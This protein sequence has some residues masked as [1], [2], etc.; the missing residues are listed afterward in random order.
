MK[1]ILIAVILS[2]LYLPTP[3][4]ATE[5]KCSDAVGDFQGRKVRS[6]KVVPPRWAKP[7]SLDEG[8]VKDNSGG[9]LA[10]GKEF[11]T[12]KLGNTM[13]AARHAYKNSRIQ[14]GFKLFE[15]DGAIEATV[16]P[17][18]CVEP[19]DTS[20]CDRCVDVTVRPYTVAIDFYRVG[21]NFLPIPRSNLPTAIAEVPKPLR[22]LD[23]SFGLSRDNEQGVSVQAGIDTD[24]LHPF[25]KREEP[26]SSDSPETLH[27][28]LRASG[29]K[30]LSKRFYRGRIALEMSQSKGSKF[31]E[32]IAVGGSFNSTH[33]P[34]G[35]GERFANELRLGT[36]LTL[37]PRA[38][39]LDTV[40]LRANYRHSN[41]RFFTPEPADAEFV[42]ENSAELRTVIDGRAAGGFSR[43]GV[44]FDANRGSGSYG[45]AAAQVG[46][47]KEIP[48]DLNRTIGLEFLAGAGKIWG[49]APEYARF[50]SGSGSANFLYAQIEDSQLIDFP[51]GPVLRSTGG[52]RGTL[53]DRKGGTSF[54]HTNLNVSFPVPGW[55]RPLI[56]NE[57]IDEVE[58]DE[59]EDGEIDLPVRPAGINN[60]PSSCRGHQG[61][62]ATLKSLVKS[63]VRSSFNIIRRYYLRLGMSPDEA[64][65]AAE[66]D[67][68]EICP[69]VFYIADYANLFE[70]KPMIMFDASHLGGG[71][72]TGHTS[73][74]AGAGAQFILV[75][76]RLE[77][78]YMKALKRSIHEQNGSIVF[79]LVFQN[80]F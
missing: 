57:S 20:E 25:S 17:S 26:A 78:G 45:R 43:I 39:V 12:E 13:T 63:S 3:G 48:L 44:W 50:H 80:L 2:A 27:L 40:L 29:E 55:S 69:G 18:P 49:R 59:D 34:F 70:V 14:N 72:A 38:A 1:A 62:P 11:T 16:I 56:P 10:A 31:L 4:Q 21:K 67:L 46:Y 52:N 36:R 6:L 30:S 75:T 77:L 22:M 54:W 74:A 7:M 35:V 73:Y 15:R 24:L 28:N 66:D 41:I 37:R 76:A 51:T 64:Q 32:Q 47:S 23:P 79:R 61:G 58:A 9:L 42:T 5:E 53:S 19:V 8:V 33:E 68:K 71:G 65:R 60:L